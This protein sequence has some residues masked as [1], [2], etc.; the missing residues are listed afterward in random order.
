MVEFGSTKILV[1][2]HGR[3]V[4][5]STTGIEDHVFDSRQGVRF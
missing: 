3:E 4:I 2:R 5:A 1:G